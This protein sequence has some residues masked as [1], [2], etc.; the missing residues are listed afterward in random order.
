MDKEF[1]NETWKE[2]ITV[3]EEELKKYDL[4]YKFK[5]KV[6]TI[7]A[8]FNKNSTLQIFKKGA[9]GVDWG[10]VQMPLG[11][12]HEQLIKDRYYFL[13]KIISMLKNSYD[14]DDKNI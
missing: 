3:V 11:L 10:V 9:D 13:E 4:H 5:I 14:L 7:D 12:A 2:V 8:D 1:T 6:Y